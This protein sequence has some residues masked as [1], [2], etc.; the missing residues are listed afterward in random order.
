M[1]VLLALGSMLIASLAC[2]FPINLTQKSEIPSLP[3][4]AIPSGNEELSIT[5]TESQLNTLVNQALQSQS[6]T[7]TNANVFVRDGKVQVKGQ[8]QQGNLSLP[9][10]LNL[11]IAAN[12]QGGIQYQILS[13]NVGFLPLPQDQID[14]I[15]SQLNQAL[16]GQIRQATENIYIENI[17]LGEGI[18]TI[19]GH[20]R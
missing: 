17:Y 18:I 3:T 6:Q 9:L 19:T 14:Q 16:D 11:F 1:F 12:G 2:N 15:S 20:A 13:A 4:Q 5:L 7:I 10:T 8:V